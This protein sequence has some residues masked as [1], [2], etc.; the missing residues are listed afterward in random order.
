MDFT[1]RRR[2]LDEYSF[3]AA[4]QS[5]LSFYAD[6]RNGAGGQK[7]DLRGNR[8]RNPDQMAERSGLKQE[9]DLWDTDGD[10]NGADGDSV[11]DP[12]DRDQR[13]PD[14]ICRGDPCYSHIPLS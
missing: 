7:R 12:W 1:A 8:D 9:K 4:D 13:K 11:C 6:T 2:Y 14:R 3:A 5:D 10:G